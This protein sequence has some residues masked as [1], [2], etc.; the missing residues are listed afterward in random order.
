MNLIRLDN[1]GDKLLKY[2]GSIVK[3]KISFSHSPVQVVSFSWW[4]FGLGKL[5]SILED[6]KTVMSCRII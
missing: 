4:D 5:V 6:E 3:V 2:V 1:C